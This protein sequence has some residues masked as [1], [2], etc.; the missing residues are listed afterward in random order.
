MSFLE[1]TWTELL[2]VSAVMLASSLA[3]TAS[4]GFVLIRLPAEYFRNDHPREFWID[5]HPILR[6]G[7]I[8]LKNLLGI[9]VF[10]IGVILSMPGVPG[11]GI[12]TILIAITLLDFP[13]KRRFERW[14][15]SRPAIFRALNHLRARFGKPALQLEPPRCLAQNHEAQRPEA[16]SPYDRLPPCVP[17][18]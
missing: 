11:P 8:V 2:V 3:A 9:V 16:E 15:V 14:L 13:G 7:G 5:R 12:L 4:V 18:R 6:W 17:R 1:L 10:A